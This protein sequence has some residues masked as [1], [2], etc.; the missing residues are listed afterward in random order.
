M[1]DA[2]TQALAQ[3]DFLNATFAGA[4]AVVVVA[5]IVKGFAGF[6]IAMISGPVLSA[7]YTP[8]EGVA[9]VLLLEIVT[10]LPLLPRAIR[11]AEW[12]LVTPLVVA[13]ALTV[14][15]G[16]AVLIGLDAAI[17]RRVIAGAA[18]TFAIILMSGWRFSARQSVPL[19]IGIGVFSGTITGA[20]GM[21]NPILLLYAMAGATPPERQ[22]ATIAMLSFLMVTVAT[23]VLLVSGAVETAAAWRAVVLVPLS[24]FCVFLGAR[25]FGRTSA[26]N[27]R[28]AILGVIVVTST[29]ALFL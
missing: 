10:S 20:T 1:L 18:L 24:L 29:I 7:L 11:L 21:G 28:R 3:G 6:G 13:S 19:S 23:V 5:S 16:A 27:F 12:Q 25:L 17:M 2:L 9:I 15:V 26:A 14:P 8:V 22:R 4:I